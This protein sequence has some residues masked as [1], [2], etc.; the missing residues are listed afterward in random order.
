MN[1]LNYRLETPK[2]QG[3]KN[4][5]PVAKLFLPLAN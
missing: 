2:L 1:E 3:A 5:W 4:N